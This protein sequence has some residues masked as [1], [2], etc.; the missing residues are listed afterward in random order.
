MCTLF[1]WLLLRGFHLFSNS[2]I[3]TI[4]YIRNKLIKITSHVLH[5]R[6]TFNR[7]ESHVLIRRVLLNKRVIF[8]FS[9]KNLKCF[10]INA[11]AIKSTGY[12]SV[13]IINAGSNPKACYRASCYLVVFGYSCMRNSCRNLHRD[14]V[15]RTRGLHPV[16]PT[17]FLFLLD[18][19]RFLWGYNIVI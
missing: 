15:Q 3:D 10:Y 1:V 16:R 4:L 5:V 18:H 6:S 17:P 12:I 7:M 2:T 9:K 14:I 8:F 11:S 19:A 13:R